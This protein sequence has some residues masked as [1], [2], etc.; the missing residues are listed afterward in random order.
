MTYLTNGWSIKPYIQIQNGLPYS[1]L[2]TGT[3]VQQCV[4]VGCLRAASSGITGTGATAYLP[5]FG[6]NTQQYPRTIEIDLRAQKQFRFAE[7]YNLE[8][9]GEAFNLANHQNVTGVNSTGYAIT[10]TGTGTLTYQTNF[11]Q[12]A[13]ANTNYAYGPRVIQIGGRVTF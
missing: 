1:L 7:R 6:R 5:F 4:A 12:T 10:G 9:F 3:A 11:G 8:V 2:S 13:T